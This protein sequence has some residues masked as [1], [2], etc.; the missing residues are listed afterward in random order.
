M[1]AEGDEQAGYRAHYCHCLADPEEERPLDEV[2]A[3]VGQSDAKVSAQVGAQGAHL[4]A[5][6]STFLAQPAFESF[7]DDARQHLLTLVENL[8][9][10]RAPAVAQPLTQFHG[11]LSIIHRS[12]IFPTRLLDD[13]GIVGSECQ[14]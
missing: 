6:L 14:D 4:D 2:G 13:D 1:L 10:D 9:E 12:T 3:L 11:P 5:Q 8:F 7:G